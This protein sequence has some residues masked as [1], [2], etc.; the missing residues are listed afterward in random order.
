VN[1]ALESAVRPPR[2]RPQ[3]KEAVKA[4]DVVV[5]ARGGGLVCI[6]GVLLLLFRQDVG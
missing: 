2:I 1:R 5:V 4:D 3:S 6:G